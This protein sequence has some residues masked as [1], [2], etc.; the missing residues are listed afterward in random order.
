MSNK[1]PVTYLPDV[2]KGDA[3]YRSYRP[4]LLENGITVL[5]ANDPQSKHFAASVSVHAGASSDP[6]GLPGLAHFCEHMCF[7]GSKAYPEENEYK[8]YLA[9]HGGKSNAS[10][11]MSHTTYQFDVLSEH[12]EKALDIFSNFFISPCLLP[13]EH[14]GRYRPWILRIVRTWS[15]MAGGGGRY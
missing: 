11:S 13:V 8:Q 12:G 3:D 2:I 6:R 15:V 14:Q 4:L 7:L 10:T 5:L 9:Q 1:S